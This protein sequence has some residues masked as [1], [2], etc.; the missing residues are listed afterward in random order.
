MTKPLSREKW[1]KCGF[2]VK[3]DYEIA[4]NGK[5]ITFK[6]CGVTSFLREDIVHMYCAFCGRFIHE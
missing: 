3:R 4:E 6:P 1:V 2:A 5:S